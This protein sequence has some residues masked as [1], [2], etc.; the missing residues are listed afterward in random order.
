MTT[1]PTDAELD[2]LA[3]MLGLPPIPASP[4]E[5]D[6]CRCAPEGARPSH[7]PEGCRCRLEAL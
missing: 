5:T 6:D 7:Q 4:H 2:R 1:V 3:A